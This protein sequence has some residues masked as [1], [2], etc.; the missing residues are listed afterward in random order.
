MLIII[1]QSD[2]EEEKYGKKLLF[3]FVSFADTYKH[4][5]PSS[6]HLYVKKFT[7]QQENPMK[8]FFF[9]SIFGF[10]HLFFLFRLYFQFW[11][12]KYWEK[13]SFRLHF[14]A[15][16]FSVNI[17]K[18]L[19][20]NHFVVE[21]LQQHKNDKFCEW[22]MLFRGNFNFST[23]I[24]IIQSEMRNTESFWVEIWKFFVNFLEK[25]FNLWKCDVW[26][27]WRRSFVEGFYEEK[28]FNEI[29]CV[30]FFGNLDKN[31][32]EWKEIISILLQRTT[33]LIKLTEKS[34]SLPTA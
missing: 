14:L 20:K 34:M 15:L 22:K 25:L 17:N 4:I 7:T 16:F 27:S 28:K 32:I 10:H 8:K 3:W 21:K 5:K 29:C 26:I 24:E 6:T 13:E 1:T 12:D 30:N 2:K 18:V 9:L 11:F 33:E 19:Q 23:N 31:E